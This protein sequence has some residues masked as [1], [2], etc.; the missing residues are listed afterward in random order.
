MPGVALALSA[1]AP[2]NDVVSVGREPG[3][4]SAAID[5]LWANPSAY[6]RRRVCVS[7]FLGRM[8]PYGE[9]RPD[10]YSTR[11]EAETRHSDRYVTIGV[12]MTI[13]SQESLSRH[14]AQPL[15]VQGVFEYD[16]RCWPR[17]GQGEA[18]Y[19]CFPSRPM[20]IANAE[21]TFAMQ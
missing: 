16:A 18:E 10:L 9:D 2:S 19:S 5:D 6:Q 3:C 1:C 21:L 11:E 15:R 12:P 7:G 20:R 14:S 8:V 17:S 4:T 13:S